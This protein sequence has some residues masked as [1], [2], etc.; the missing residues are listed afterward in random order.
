MRIS[1]KMSE[2]KITTV[3]EPLLLSATDAAKCLSIC[4]RTLWKYTKSGEI[5]CV[6][7]GGRVLYDPNALRDW[8][9]QEKTK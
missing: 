9:N 6:R 5:P 3:M 4:E 7:L 1:T 8:I 2:E